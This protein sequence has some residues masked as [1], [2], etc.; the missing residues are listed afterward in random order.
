MAV[1][2]VAA[3]Y[4]KVV[5]GSICHFVKV[6]H[7]AVRSKA[8]YSRKRF[9]LVICLYRIVSARYAY[10][11]I[12]C[13]SRTEV[14]GVSLTAYLLLDARKSLRTFYAYGNYFGRRCPMHAFVIYSGGKSVFARRRPYRKKSGVCVKFLICAK[15][16]GKFFSR[17]VIAY[18][19]SLKFVSFSRRIRRH[20][21]KFCVTGGYGSNLRSFVAEIEVDYVL[22]LRGL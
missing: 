1:S 13:G 6:K 5:V 22:G 3:L 8:R 2:F 20:V 11:V 19:P 16:Y 12:A 9:I 15:L 14:Y 4:S 10:F 7:A 18:P 21:D 17:F